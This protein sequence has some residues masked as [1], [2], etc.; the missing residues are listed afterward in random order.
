MPQFF[1]LSVN[2]NLGAEVARQRIKSGIVQFRSTFGH[3]MSV[4]ETWINDHLDFKVGFMGQMA[5]GT[6]DVSDTVVRLDV[7]L[8]GLLGFFADKVQSL[9]RKKGEL[10]LE[11]QQN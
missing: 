2:H 7:H 6:L 11:H 4:E 8:P 9:V 5:T 3:H 1:S 10:L